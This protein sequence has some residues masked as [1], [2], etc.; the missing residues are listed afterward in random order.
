MKEIAYQRNTASLD[1]IS[2][3]NDVT[4]YYFEI[5]ISCEI[6]EHVADILKCS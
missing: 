4:D 2:I 3:N 5:Q 1:T 6:N